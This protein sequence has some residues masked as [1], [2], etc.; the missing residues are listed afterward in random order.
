M[1]KSACSTDRRWESGQTLI[2]VTLLLPW[3][4]ALA[5]GASSIAWAHWRR[6][7]CAHAAFETAH[8]ILHGQSVANAA[9]PVEVRGS[10]SG[11]RARARCGDRVESV[12]LWEIED[13][14]I[15]DR[16]LGHHPPGRDDRPLERISW[17]E[18]KSRDPARDRSVRSTGRAGLSRS[19]RRDRGLEQPNSYAPSIASGRPGAHDADF[20]ADGPRGCVKSAGFRSRLMAGEAGPMASPRELPGRAASPLI[21][22]GTR[23]ALEA[24]PTRS[25]RSPSGFLGASYT[26]GLG[27]VSDRPSRTTALH[28]RIRAPVK[29]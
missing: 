14:G 24:R 4:V 17:L 15:A 12:E 13:V 2:E 9:V 1:R 8:A 20:F 18:R 29:L 19:A 25:P 16:P 5:V 11:V 28:T 21:R 10:P 27:G 6:F 26:A 23:I 22:S 7:Q 3:V